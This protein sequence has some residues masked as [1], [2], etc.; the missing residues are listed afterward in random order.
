ML[1]NR[2]TFFSGLQN[3]WHDL[4]TQ[5]KCDQLD[6]VP[7]RQW[8]SEGKPRTKAT[9][10][11]R[12]KRTRSMGNGRIKKYRVVAQK[13]SCPNGRGDL[14]KGVC[15]LKESPNKYDKRQAERIMDEEHDP[16]IDRCRKGH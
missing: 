9:S 5:K 4:E 12:W 3:T 2:N 14:G 13:K 8:E 15:R 7:R 16:L 1:R 6:E 10:Y 11:Q